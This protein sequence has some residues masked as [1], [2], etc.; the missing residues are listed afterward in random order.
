M[1]KK[2]LIAC[3]YAFLQ[4]EYKRIFRVP[5]LPYIQHVWNK[6]IECLKP[7]MYEHI[8]S[9]MYQRISVWLIIYKVPKQR[10]INKYMYIHLLMFMY[11][12]IA[13]NF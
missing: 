4:Y 2:K 11:R 9:N 7:C 8:Y 13:H 12:F 1:I 3:L 5:V 6:M 10:R